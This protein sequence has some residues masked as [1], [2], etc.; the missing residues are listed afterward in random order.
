VTIAF[1]ATSGSAALINTA[2]TTNWTHTPAGTP[3]AVVGLVPQGTSTDTVT[4]LS[5]GGVAM[6]RIRRVPRSSAEAC[7]VYTYFLGAGIPTGAQTV[8]IVTTGTAPKWPQVV[9]FTAADDCEVNVESGVDAGVV[10]NPSI[11]ITPTAQA[12]ICYVC[13]SGLNTPVDTPETDTIRA[14]FRD[15]G[16]IS[17]HTGYKVVSAGATTIGWTSASDDA[18]HAAIAVIETRLI[19]PRPVSVGPSQAVHQSHSW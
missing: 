19:L 12:G 1:D 8:S 3:R 9:T 15:L 17:G 16:T 18:C 10:A 5:Y 2:T 7:D 4:S 14:S 13:S 6:T 11:A